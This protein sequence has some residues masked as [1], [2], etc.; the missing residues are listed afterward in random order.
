MTI[1]NQEEKIKDMANEI[2]ELRNKS[3]PKEINLICD[4]NRKTIAPALRHKLGTEW[5][6]TEYQQIYTTQQLSNRLSIDPG[7]LRKRTNIIILGI[8]DVKFGDHHSAT[9][10]INYIKD[11]TDQE[12]TIFVNIPPITIETGNEEEN[13]DIQIARTTVN[14]HINSTFQKTV[15]LNE[16]K[17]IER[18]QPGTIV[19]QDGIHL[20]QRGGE[21]VAKAIAEVLTGEQKTTKKTQV[22]HAR[23]RTRKTTQQ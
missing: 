19:E 15:K 13:E 17:T 7:M 11:H 10:N 6:I 12:A 18:R 22:N 5:D 1:Q 8:N 21:E 20:T 14:R 16:I 2:K 23:A 3:T 4:S 9:Q